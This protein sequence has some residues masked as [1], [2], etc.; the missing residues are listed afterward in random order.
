MW[1]TGR[2]ILCCIISFL[3]GEGAG[4]FIIGLFSVNKED[5]DNDNKQ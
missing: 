1:S 4:L 5:N 2:V 3:L